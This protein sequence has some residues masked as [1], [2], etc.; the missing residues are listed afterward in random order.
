MVL[1]LK[2]RIGVVDTT[3]ARVDMAGAA[4]EEL[5]GLRVQVVR[6][7]VPGIKDLAVECKR[8]LDG[9][10]DACLAL[11]WVGGAPIDSQCAHEASLGIQWAKLLTGKHIVEAF[12]HER[13]AKSGKEL[14]EIAVDRARKHA[15][16]AYWLVAK[17]GELTKHAGKGLRQGKRHAGPLKVGKK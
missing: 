6:R 10:C 9:G 3:F 4:L 11:G 12:V 15:L 2:V 8:L 7:T 5:R 13:E 14:C 16:N 1:F 17:P